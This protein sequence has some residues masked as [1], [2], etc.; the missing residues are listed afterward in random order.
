MNNYLTTLE[1]LEAVTDSLYE[2]TQT[3]K[4]INLSRAL[5]YESMIFDLVQALGGPQTETVQKIY[6]DYFNSYKKPTKQINSPYEL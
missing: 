2:K 1:L 6:K 5:F 3:E 4:D